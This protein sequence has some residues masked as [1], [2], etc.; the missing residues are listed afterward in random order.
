MKWK[1]HFNNKYLR[2]RIIII[3][4]FFLVYIKMGSGLSLDHKNEKLNNPRINYFA[5]KVQR[6]FRDNQKINKINKINCVPIIFDEL[7]EINKIPNIINITQ[8]EKFFLF[9]STTIITQPDNKKH[10]VGEITVG[11]FLKYYVKDIKLKFY[12]KMNDFTKKEEDQIDLISDNIIINELIKICKEGVIMENL[13]GPIYFLKYLDNDSNTS[14]EYLIKN[15]IRVDSP[16]QINISGEKLDEILFLAVINN[17]NIELNDEKREEFGE[18]IIKF[19]TKVDSPDK[20]IELVKMK[21]IDEVIKTIKN[22]IELS[23]EKREEFREKLIT[24]I[25]Y[26]FEICCVLIEPTISIYIKKNKIDK[27]LIHPI[28][29]KINQSIDY[30]ICAKCLLKNEIVNKT[31]SIEILKEFIEHSESMNKDNINKCNIKIKEILD[32]KEYNIPIEEYN[33]RKKEII[34]RIIF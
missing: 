2:R 30:T 6:K 17:N 33:N 9:N 11:D 21:D 7:K 24:E 31:N 34:K 3:N 23:N 18:F 28:Y 4:Y 12:K 22:E 16:Y 15:F 20:I 26:I 25:N 32:S 14:L 1:Y 27:N 8:L 10:T 5:T 13:I 29:N 19:L